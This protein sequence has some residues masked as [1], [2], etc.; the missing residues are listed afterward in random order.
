M[1][2]PNITPRR[3]RKTAGGA[4]RVV[5]IAARFLLINVLFFI[6]SAPF[7]VLYGPFENIRSTAIGTVITSRHHVW[8]RYVMSSETY[9]R[10][11]PQ[12]LQS[13]SDPD[14][15]ITFANTHSTEITLHHVESQRFQGY[16]LEIRDPSRVKVGTSSSLGVKGEGTSEIAR[17]HGAVAAVNASGFLDPLGTGTGKTPDG[18]IIKNGS[19]V[20]GKN[21]EGKA[22]L[23]GLDKNGV[24]ISG[25]YTVQE[26]RRLN[27]RDGISFNWPNLI[28]NGKKQ[29]TEAISAQYGLQ[30]RTAIG[31]KADG[32]IL[33]LVIDGRQ[34]NSVGASLLDV[35]NTLYDEFD[36]VTAAVLDGGA[37]STMYY[38]GN[39]IN[40]PSLL[41]GERLVPSAIIVM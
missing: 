13:D 14:D 24:L 3:R 7:I 21:I 41:L 17:K 28:N 25:W 9:N 16:L 40:S 38:N 26:I 1:L 39:V 22:H 15:P 8:L 11:L 19:F 4:R 10:Y 33:L 30:P 18:L 36:A 2:E 32:T 6:L 20:W 35:T 23:V 37:S 5:I 31:Q 29:M 34:T 12:G 27:I